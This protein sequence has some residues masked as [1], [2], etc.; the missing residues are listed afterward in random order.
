MWLG[1]LLS[2]VFSIGLARIIVNS[3]FQSIINNWAEYRC[4][5]SVIIFASLFKNKKDPRSDVQFTTENFEFCASEIAQNALRVALKPIMDVFYQMANAAMQSIGFTMN[6]RTL[7][8]NLFNGLNR[9]F[10]IFTRRFNLTFHELHMS[11]IKQFSAIQK[12]NAIATA[13]VFSA[14][15]LIRSILN[16]FQLMIIICI[17]ILVIMIVLVIFLWFIFAPV[18]PLILVTIGVI[19]A[20]ASA[21]AVGGMAGTFCFEKNTVIVMKDGYAPIK[22]II[23]GDILADGSSVSAI[24]KFAYDGSQLFILDG[25]IVS[26]SHIVYINGKPMFVKDCPDALPYSGCLTE[27]YCLNTTSHKIRVLGSNVDIVFADWEELGDSSMEEW[28]LLVRKMLNS[29]NSVGKCNAS[30]LNSESGFS[31]AAKV[32]TMNGYVEL[33]YISIGDQIDDG[34]G[35]TTITGK[36][37]LD[38]EEC[39]EMGSIGECQLSGATWIYEN[40]RWIRAAESIR[41]RLEAPVNRVI[42]IFTESGKLVVDKVLSRDF[43]DIGIKNINKTYDFTK[44]RL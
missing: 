6:L 39:S 43:S 30:I 26:G 5:P 35:W 37:Y 20:T 9:M 14:I 18:L 24:M 44:S 41:W 8:S 32:K 19:S 11:F 42:S 38:G 3:D 25:I 23:I 28:D 21:A 40:N 2:L 31:T 1:I 27:L 17:S 12:A 4:N 10:D 16:F 36:V 33:S 34:D 22:D 13:S 29:D 15:S 7:G